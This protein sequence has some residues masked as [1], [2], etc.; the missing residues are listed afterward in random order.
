MA[1]GQGMIEWY[2]A[3]ISALVLMVA[4]FSFFFRIIQVDGASMNPTL[5]GRGTS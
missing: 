4:L 2:E 5:W 1:R 3:R